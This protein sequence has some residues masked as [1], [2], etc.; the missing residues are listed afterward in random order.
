ME[1]KK[2]K[3][4]TKSTYPCKSKKNMSKLYTGKLKPQYEKN[5]LIGLFDLKTTKN[6]KETCSLNMSIKDKPGQSE[7][8]AFMSVLKHVCDELPKLNEAKFYDSQIQSSRG[9][10]IAENSQ[11]L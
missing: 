10:A 4:K 3:I 6:I 7:R 2:I 9:H 1:N 8:Y 11:Q 5:D